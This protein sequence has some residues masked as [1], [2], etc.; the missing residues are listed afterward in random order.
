MTALPTPI[1]TIMLADLAVLVT[2]VTLVTV[3]TVLTLMS[4]PMVPTAVM[5]T[6]H[7]LTLMVVTHVLVTLDTEVTV[8]HALIWT[9]VH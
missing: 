6:P 3:K 5:I 4:V 9:N 8:N 2:K 1:A 7:V